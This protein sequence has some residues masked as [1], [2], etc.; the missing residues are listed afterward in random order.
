MSTPMSDQARSSTPTA[1]MGDIQTPVDII[2][3]IRPGSKSLYQPPLPGHGDR[4]GPDDDHDTCGDDHQ[5][6]V[7]DNCGEDHKIASSCDRWECPRC[8]KR[9]VLK[10]AIRA[11]AKLLHYRDKYAESDELRFHRVI[12]SPPQDEDFSTVADPLDRFYEVAGDLLEQGGGYHGGIRIPHPYRHADEP[13]LGPDADDRDLALVGGDDDQGI[14]K[15]TLPDWSDDHTPSWSETE[16]KLSHEPHMHCYIVA[17]AFWL[18][19][20]KIYEETGWFIRR[21]EPYQG[22]NVSCY[23]AD[24]LVRSVMY[25]LSHCGDYDGRDHYRFFGAMAN[26]S[27]SDAQEQRASKICREYA[28]HILGL[29]TSSVTCQRDLSDEDIDSSGGS[30]SGGD[31]SGDGSSDEPSPGEDES[32]YE[33]CNGRLVHIRQVPDLLDDHQDDWPDGTVARLENLYE[34]IV[35]EPPPG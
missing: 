16:E 11:T 27:A 2:E 19:T 29:S 13:D 1:S 7:C 24:D 20:E 15:H 26:E 23:N 4:Y 5:W 10:A 9:A 25:A 8:Y 34:E 18:P 12:I 30:S 35:G 14:W 31:G 6:R 22:N 21:L 3:S 17:D 32:E 33:P 28:N